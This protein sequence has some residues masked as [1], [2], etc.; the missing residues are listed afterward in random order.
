MDNRL[1]MSHAFTTTAVSPNDHHWMRHALH[2]AQ[3][4]AAAGEVP[5][6]AVLV[7]DGQ[8]LGEGCNAPIALRDPT[9]HAEILALRQAAQRVGNYRLEGCTLYVTLEP[10]AMCS[11]ALL[12]ARVGRVVYGAREPKTGAAGS[13][14]DVFALPQLNHHTQVQGGV[15]AEACA[16]VLADFFRARRLVL[17]QNAQPVRQDA[18][19]TPERRFV[20]WPEW[21]WPQ[22]YVAS[23]PTLE[24]LRLHYADEGPPT[25]PVW[26]LLH[27]AQGSGYGLRHLM[28][29][30]LAAG[31]RVLVPDWIGFG[32]SDKPKKSSWHTPEKHMQI[33]SELLEFLQISPCYWVAQS[34]AA[35]V[36][37][38][39]R[40]DWCLQ[41][42][43]ALDQSAQ[44][45]P[46]PDAGHGA[47]VRIWQQWQSQ[48]VARVEARWLS[49][50][51][52]DAAT[53]Q[54]QVGAAMEYLGA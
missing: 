19:R 44:Q 40:W 22:R 30:L 51:P 36:L 45:A 48:A 41:G 26:L 10:C 5:V 25:A 33:L 52:A 53:A 34:G 38:A 16:G 42:E 28:A 31:Q 50:M 12:Q 6:G 54:A 17:R 18:L 4:A 43:A 3:Q 7:R 20:A 8:V 39:Q 46:F 14:L 29:A 1:A 35:Q 37:P 27:D 23:L 13:V 24:G 9:A 49:P 32:R 2:L 15:C 47:G 21:P 11:G